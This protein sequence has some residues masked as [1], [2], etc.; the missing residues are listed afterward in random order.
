MTTRNISNKEI[1]N[2]TLNST[3][4]SS[5]RVL[6]N[7]TENSFCAPYANFDGAKKIALLTNYDAD[8]LTQK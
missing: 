7:Q 3:K 6:A 4:M 2:Q 1:T 8:A 5:T